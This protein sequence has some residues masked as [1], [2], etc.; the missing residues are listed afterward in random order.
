MKDVDTLMFFLFLRALN[1][2]EVSD[3]GGGTGVCEAEIEAQKAE[4]LRCY[5]ML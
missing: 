4:R 1:H 2:L 3:V 5:R